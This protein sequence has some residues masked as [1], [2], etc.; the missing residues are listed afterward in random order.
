MVRV[1]MPSARAPSPAVSEE[2]PAK[3]N[4]LKDVMTRL[5][6]I[7]DEI[8]NQRQEH[9][10]AVTELQQS[11][12]ESTMQLNRLKKHTYGRDQYLMSGRPRSLTPSRLPSPN[13][14]RSTTSMSPQLPRSP[15]TP[16]STTPSSPLAAPG[17]PNININ[18]TNPP[19]PNRKKNE[20]ENVLR[21][22]GRPGHKMT[23][24]PGS[25]GL[26]G[27][28]VHRGRQPTRNCKRRKMN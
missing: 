26:R 14:E 24:A 22:R 11:C 28:R 6:E 17:S 5:S 4:M 27:G 15:M 12:Q 7:Q 8:Q 18:I 2:A 23:V 9:Q 1:P 16:L 20:K 13:M 19:R 21:S 3:P 25:R 10:R